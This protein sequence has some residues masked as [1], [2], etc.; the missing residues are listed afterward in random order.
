MTARGSAKHSDMETKPD[1]LPAGPEGGIRRVETLVLGGGIAGLAFAHGLDPSA[2][3]A[4]IEASDRLGGLI[5]TGNW[6]DVHYEHGPEALQDNAAE[7]VSLFEELGLQRIDAHAIANHRYIHT[8]RG[9]LPVP[10]GPGALL[11]SPLLSVSGKLRA[12]TEPLRSGSKGLEGSIA[13]FVRHRL[14]SE[15]LERLVDPA[16]AG[17]YA[18]DPEKLS[19]RAAFPAVAELVSEH[20]SLLSGMLARLRAKKEKQRELENQRSLRGEPSQKPPSRR[21]PSLMSVKGGLERLPEAI[22]RVLGERV[23]RGRS[24]RRVWRRKDGTENRW[25]IECN[26]TDL[27]DS[28]ASSPA[29]KTRTEVW[30]ARHLVLA[31][32]AGCA[33]KLLREDQPELSQEMGSMVSEAVLSVTHVWP[34]EAVTHP[35]DGFGYLVPSR[36]EMAH[37]GT[38]F[39][40]S[41]QPE[42]C[43][44]E[45]VLLRTLMGGARRPDLVHEPDEAVLEIVSREVGGVLGFAGAP[46]YSSVVRWPTALPRYDLNQ[47]A[48][49]ATIDRLLGGLAGLSIIGNHRRGISVNALIESSRRAAREHRNANA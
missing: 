34:R 41:I 11:R 47:V 5:R 29:E 36:S 12:L 40:S 37:L 43:P 3:F 16:V 48:R 9:L 10:M 21:A 38:L 49:Q 1:A 15:V 20:G 7:T 30:E 19:L 18:G 44:G 26:L 31:V 46:L 32:P 33:E 23:Y 17:I 22:G 25:V 24:A 14:G 8:E 35:L 42:R 13:D 27:G 28:D 2:D 4:L 39:S 45:R 6:E